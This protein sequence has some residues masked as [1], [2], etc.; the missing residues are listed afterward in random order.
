M[1][2]RERFIK[3][4]RREPLTGHVPTFEL[5]FFLTM[6]ALGKVHP[7][8]RHYGQWNQLSVAEKKAQID[9][10]AELYIVTAQKYHHS[11]NF[12]DPN[13]GDFDN[14]VR[15]LESIREKSGED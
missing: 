2:E 7:S 15:P 8:Q 1:T 9:D 10:Q 6:E 5:V 11:A 14:R 4:L 13:P 3:A 12:V